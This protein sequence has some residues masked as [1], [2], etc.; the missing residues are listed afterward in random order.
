MP[1]HEPSS[2]PDPGELLKGPVRVRRDAEGRLHV[3]VPDAKKRP[4]TEARPRPPH[5]DDPRSGPLRDAGPTG[6]LA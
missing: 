5:A 1:R 4:T 6:G 2:K 3:V